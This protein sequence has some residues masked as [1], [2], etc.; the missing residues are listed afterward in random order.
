MVLAA[1]I[2]PE[3]L[4][5]LVKRQPTPSDWIVSVHDRSGRFIARSHEFKR[6]VGEHASR[7]LLQAMAREPHGTLTGVTREGIEVLAAH[8]R[9]AYTGWSVAVGIPKATLLHQLNLSL[10]VVF[11]IVVLSIGVGLFAA[12]SIARRMKAA[13]IA[14]IPAAEA[15]SRSEKVELPPDRYVETQLLG[16]ALKSASAKLTSSEYSAQHDALTGLPNRAFLQV[17]LPRM[18]S[19]SLRQQ[20]ALT[21]LYLDLDGFKAVNDS[22]GHAAGDE[23]LTLT[24][25][26]IQACIR[27]ADIGVRLGGDEFVVVLPNTGRAGALETAERIREALGQPIATQCGEARVSVSIGIASFPEDCATVDD[28]FCLADKAMYRAKHGGKNTV[29][30]HREEAHS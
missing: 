13:I 6:F 24:A 26:R 18:H 27:S 19:Q 16:E 7:D 23:V 9:S 2:L 30:V 4:T 25:E 21:L 29:S 28:L 10:L 12:S 22:L 3:R 20:S 14:M 15:L 8:T 5:G 11:A 1:T 17:L